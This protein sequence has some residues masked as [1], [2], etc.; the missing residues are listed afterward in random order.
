MS[1]DNHTIET[2]KKQP[3]SF[4]HLSIEER[5]KIQTYLDE[6]KSYR[7]VSKALNRSVSTISDEVKRG[8]VQQRFNDKEVLKYF[9]DA[10]ERIYQKN[11]ENCKSTGL[12]RYSETFL[13]QLSVTLLKGKRGNKE[14]R[15]QSVESFTQTYDKKLMME[16]F[17]LLELHTESSPQVHCQSR[18]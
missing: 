12:E 2:L 18:T 10:G 4:K 17:H 5:R 11:R 3:R 8:T 14:L 1:N 6:G 15:T 9:P 7:F 13:I 16:S